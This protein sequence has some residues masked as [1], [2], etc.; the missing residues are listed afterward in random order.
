M[1][2]VKFTA[3]ISGKQ[4]YLENTMP[5]KATVTKLPQRML[6]YSSHHPHIAYSIVKMEVVIEKKP[7]ASGK[8]LLW[9]DVLKWMGRNPIPRERDMKDL[10]ESINLIYQSNLTCQSR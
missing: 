3:I 5:Y 1:D 4:G 8:S 2:Y 7:L 10:K 6:E 9:W